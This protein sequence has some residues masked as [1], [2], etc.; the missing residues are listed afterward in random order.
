[1]LSRN[2]PIASLLLAIIVVFTVGQDSARA[3]TGPLNQ[4]SQFDD[5]SSANLSHREWSA[6]LNVMVMDDRGKLGYGRLS[7]E[8]HE[9]LASYLQRLQRLTVSAFSK[10]EQLAYWLNFYNAGS[11]ALLFEA[12]D[13]WVLRASNK[14]LMNPN[15][16][17]KYN[18]RKFVE[19]KTGAMTE[20]RF[21][22]EG[23]S[24]SLADIKNRILFAHWSSPYVIYG[25]SCAAKGCPWTQKSP[26]MGRSVWN[27]LQANARTFINRPEVAKI[28][29]KG[30]LLS[31]YYLWNSAQ[32]G[33]GA[34]LMDHLRSIAN[35][36]LKVQLAATDGPYDDDFS[37][38]LNGE[39]PPL[40]PGQR[41][42]PNRGS[43]EFVYGP[44]N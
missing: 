29:R 35:D 14:K 27:Q 38:Y 17:P 11:L 8:G 19:G 1:M 40:R 16:V 23:V 12:L 21:V 10:D 5:T 24:L 34:A 26:Y 2:Q 3:E 6:V 30:L 31:S 9:I 7:P 15:Y 36:E 42:L 13:K 20:R 41:G 33:Q 37:W 4:F 25:L 43:G 18:P 22:V 32:V 39:L 28:K 44:S